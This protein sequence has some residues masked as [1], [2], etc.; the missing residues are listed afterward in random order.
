[1]ASYGLRFGDLDWSPQ[2]INDD[3]EWRVYG[4]KRGKPVP[5][6][7]VA[8]SMFRDGADESVDRYDNRDQQVIVGIRGSDS[9]VRAEA[10]TALALECQKRRNELAW[11]P[12]DGYGATTVFEVL[13]ADLEFDES[14][15]WDLA[16]LRQCEAVYI[17][18][19]RVRPFGMSESEVVDEALTA[20]ASPVTY[21][22]SD[23]SSATGWS[24]PDGSVS[25]SGGVLRPPTVWLSRVGDPIGQRDTY[26]ALM[27]SALSSVDFSATPYVSM[28]VTRGTPSSGTP[29]AV[30]SGSMLVDGVQLSLISSQSLSAITS[31]YTYRCDDPSATS[32]T[33]A[34]TTAVYSVGKSSIPKPSQSLV[35]DNI[36]ASN[37]PPG[38]SSTGRETLRVLTIRGSARTEG[39]LQVM[40]ETDTLGD[41]AIYS[42]PGL[43]VGGT[44]DMKRWRVSGGT[45][46]PNT[47]TASG[48]FETLT[49]GEGTATVF[50]VPADSLPRG[51]Y[52]AY[53]RVGSASG[54]ISRSVSLS[55]ATLVGSTPYGK[56]TITSDVRS[57]VTSI[58]SWTL[59]PIG[60]LVLPPTDVPDGSTANVE[61][62]L[63]ASGSDT[64]FDELLLFYAG[65]GSA[66]TIVRAGNNNS[67]PVL[68][69]A[70]NRLF[71]DTPTLDRPEHAIWVGTTA[72]RS[73]AF[74]AGELTDGWGVHPLEA[75]EAMFFVFNGGKA[76]NP[77]LTVA[78]RPHWWLNA[79]VLDEDS[80]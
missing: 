78:H 12:E 42:R 29:T 46:T 8:E 65:E 70:H 13:W 2:A 31:R 63:W 53:A 57:L 5:V 39:R 66:L 67:G 32:I 59:V 64:Q 73:D 80:A 79:Q 16:E 47:S 49:V 68:G 75:G 25:A 9:Q 7:R 28:D 76:T 43:G 44:P 11:T 3:V 21:T 18:T 37:Q 62:K 6:A 20:G 17:V 36:V 54:T 74:F 61:L 51:G 72:D 56:Q 71:L 48:S 34:A 45:M 23:G 55:A 52:L 38:A 60:E 26:R 19:F 77:G 41:V 33:V 15:D 50:H 35:F 14:G 69:S 1:M 40:H 30:L 27:S 24:S 4:L 22:V 58:P 10:E